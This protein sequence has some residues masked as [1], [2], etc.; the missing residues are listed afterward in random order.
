MADPRRDI[1]RSFVETKATSLP[2]FALEQFL[3]L[4]LQWIPSVV[5]IA[6]RAAVYPLLFSAQGLCAIEENV[7]ICHAKNLRLGRRVYIGCG[8]L[9]GASDGGIELG[10]DVRLM[11]Q[12]YLNV[13]NYEPRARIGARIVL[14]R[15]V[16]LSVG[17]AIHGHSGVRLGA[18]TIV[19]PHAVFVSGNHGQLEAVESYRTVAVDRTTPIEI[20]ANVWIGANVS[21][22]PNA[23]VGENSI[24]GAGSVVTGSLPAN[25][26]CAGSPAKVIRF[27]ETSPAQ[28]GNASRS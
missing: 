8:S 16:V 12:N 22:L 10:D 26:I 3:F 1:L 2:R 15:D 6:L 5:G 23:R 14:E 11:G 4:L 27:L 24:I 25:A 19:G 21:I 9:L 17:C 7:T 18:G 13:F 20:G 28:V